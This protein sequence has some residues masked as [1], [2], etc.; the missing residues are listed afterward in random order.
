MK[1]NNHGVTNEYQS[2]LKEQLELW[3]YTDPNLIILNGEQT[4]EEI[5]IELLDKLK[6]RNI[7]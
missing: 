4:T 6:E 5:A 1:Q 3:A 2:R 7:L